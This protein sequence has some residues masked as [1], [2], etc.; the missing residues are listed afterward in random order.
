MKYVM[1]QRPGDAVF[2]IIGCAP[3]S[4]AELLAA[5][6][7]GARAVSAGF[8]RFGAD[9]TVTTHGESTSLNLKPDMLDA[10][11]IAAHHAATLRTNGI[12]V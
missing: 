1:I 4:H 11:M 5:A 2:P 8:V 6:G 12:P 9:R 10:A 3:L 7:P